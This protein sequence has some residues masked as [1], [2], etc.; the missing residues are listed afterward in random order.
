MQLQ[1]HIM[2]CWKH[3]LMNTMTYWVGAFKKYVCCAGGR[4]FLKSK[5]KQTREAGSSLSVR[6]LCE[7]NC[8]SPVCYVA[9]QFLKDLLFLP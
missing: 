9:W 5:Q 2:T 7:K 8:L 1:N 4:G 6:S 3:F